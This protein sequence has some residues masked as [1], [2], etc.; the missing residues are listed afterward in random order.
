ME[1]FHL[2]WPA[3]LPTA[4]ACLP[5]SLPSFRMPCQGQASASPAGPAAL[6][7]GAEL[8]W[9]TVRLLGGVQ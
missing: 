1:L 9:M 6:Q 3:G 7:A 8:P 5:L 2:A 4:A